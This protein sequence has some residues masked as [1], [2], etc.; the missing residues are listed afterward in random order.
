MLKPYV[1]L[2]YIARIYQSLPRFHRQC[3]SSARRYRYIHNAAAENAAQERWLGGLLYMFHVQRGVW[4]CTVRKRE[5]AREEKCMCVWCPGKRDS[6]EI[7]RKGMGFRLVGMIVRSDYVFTSLP[8]EERQNSLL[9]SLAA[10]RRMLVRTFELCMDTGCRCN[11]YCLR[12][13]CESDS[14]D[15]AREQG[16]GRY[17]QNNGN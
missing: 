16:R 2:W 4:A 11:M 12:C 14:W 1:C 13:I 10:I 8:V 7:G 9:L 5:G 17:N 15:L 3:R 6:N